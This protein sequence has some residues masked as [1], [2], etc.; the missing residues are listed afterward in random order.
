MIYLTYCLKLEKL[1]ICYVFSKYIPVYVLV[2]FYLGQNQVVQ[3]VFEGSHT[4][5]SDVASHCVLH[6]CFHPIF[7]KTK[8]VVIVMVQ[9]CYPIVYLI[10]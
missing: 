10:V 9:L 2:I 4:Y 7:I 8:G 6:R 1:G 5:F 3:A